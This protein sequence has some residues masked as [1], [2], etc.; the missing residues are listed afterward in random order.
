MM[1]LHHNETGLIR[2]AAQS[3]FGCRGDARRDIG[4]LLGRQASHLL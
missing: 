3:C 1:I 2:A 4:T